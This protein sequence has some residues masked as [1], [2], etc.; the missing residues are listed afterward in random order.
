MCPTLQYRLC[1]IWCV[2][3]V[4]T[5][6]GTVC[7]TTGV[8]AWGLCV[9]AIWAGRRMN[10]S[11][12]CDIHYWDSDSVVTSEP[13]SELS[14]QLKSPINSYITGIMFQY[15]KYFDKSVIHFLITRKATS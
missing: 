9:C 14:L 5:F 15:M 12:V 8:H 4:S 13:C 1:H 3:N 11:T 2:D 10:V 7:T 6:T